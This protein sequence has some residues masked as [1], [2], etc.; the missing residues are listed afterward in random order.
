M[1]PSPAKQRPAFSVAG[2]HRY[3]SRH[4]AAPPKFRD[5]GLLLPPHNVV[6]IGTAGS[7][8]E[9]LEPVHSDSS[10]REV[11]TEMTKIKIRKLDKLETTGDRKN[12][13]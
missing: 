4:R 10:V 3:H 12:N 6:L 5:I 8:N 13:T 2:L 1:E 7:E 11:V 9:F